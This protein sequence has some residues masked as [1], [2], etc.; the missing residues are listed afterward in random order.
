MQQDVLMLLYTMIFFGGA[1]L[2]AIAC[3]KLR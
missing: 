1:F 2:Y 3:R